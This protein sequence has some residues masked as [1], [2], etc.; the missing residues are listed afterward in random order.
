MPTTRSVF[1]WSA[2]DELD[3]AL[4]FPANLDVL[5]HALARS[6]ARF[7]VLDPVMAFLDASVMANSDQ[8]VRR[9]LAPLARLAVLHRCAVLLVRHLNKHGGTHALYRGGGSIGLLAACRSGW[10][11]GRDPHQP[12]RRVLAQEKNNLAGPQPSLAYELQVHADT[13]PT[14]AWLSAPVRG[15]AAQLLATH[16]AGGPP[17]YPASRSASVLPQAWPS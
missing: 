17:T 11:I 1:V 16:A 10:L 4:R 14:I 9:A 13:P 8:G 3:Q 2:Q 5:D 6:D 12:E 7:L 15:A